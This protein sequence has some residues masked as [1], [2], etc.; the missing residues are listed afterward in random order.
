[1]SD[2]TKAQRSLAIKAEHNEQHR[3]DHLYRLICLEEWID[4]ALAS[5]LSN[6]G[7][8][9]AGIDGITRR[10]LASQTAKDKMIQV[11]RQELRNG[12]FRPKPVRRIYIPKANGKQRPIGIATVKDRVVQMLLKI[13]LYLFQFEMRLISFDK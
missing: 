13:V 4:Y 5:V 12:S 10:E 9:T 8:R 1:M 2:I 11:I 7:S 3:F 6:K